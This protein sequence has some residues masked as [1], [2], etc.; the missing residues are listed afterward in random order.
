MSPK[1]LLSGS[2]LPSISAFYPAT[3]PLNCVACWFFFFLSIIHVHLPNGF[4]IC[5][6]FTF[7]LELFAFALYLQADNLHLRTENSQLGIENHKTFIYFPHICVHISNWLI[8]NTLECHSIPRSLV[9]RDNLLELIEVTYTTSRRAQ[10]FKETLAIC[11]F[12]DLLS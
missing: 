11:S 4:Y 8:S 2:V 12:V 5:F 6:S 9:L 7:G 1:C 10:F 3:F